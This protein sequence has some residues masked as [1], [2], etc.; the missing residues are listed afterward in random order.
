[1]EDSTVN[2]IVEDVEFIY[3]QENTSEW[4]SIVEKE[5]NTSVE[6]GANSSADLKTRWEFLNPI[7]LYKNKWLGAKPEGI[8]LERGT[9]RIEYTISS[10]ASKGSGLALFNRETRKMEQ[11]LFWH[12]G[13]EKSDTVVN[14]SG[15]QHLTIHFPRVMNITNISGDF[16][17]ENVESAFIVTVFR[18]NTVP[19]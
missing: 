15:K 18:L 6:V 4:C 1:M 8:S 5:A 19:E 12:F 10:I 14:M 11:M 2:N 13:V 9:Y 3:S 16:N 17:P 7:L